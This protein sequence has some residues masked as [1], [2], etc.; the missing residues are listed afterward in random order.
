MND[1]VPM[2]SGRTAETDLVPVPVWDIWVRLFHWALVVVIAASFIT[3]QVGDLD[4]HYIAGLAVLGL[5][6]FRIL[7]GLV[8]SPTARFTHFIR[9]PRA[10]L[11]YLKYALG[12]RPSFS[13]GHN[14]AGAAMVAVLLFLLLMQAVSGLFNTDDILFE[15]P[16][17]DNA[18]SAVAGFMGSWHARFGNAILALIFIHVVVVLLYRL[19][20][21]ENLVRAMI[22]GKA[23]LPRPVAT[24]VTR[25]G[26][27]VFAS[28]LKA[29]LCAVIAAA[30][31]LA[32]H[33]LN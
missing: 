26:E 19:V 7:W 10:I 4:S 31:P 2:E 11:A 32:I 21:G 22:L 28:P 16:L 18:S 24:A 30:V 6:I 20:K 13:F 17:Y 8:G 12:R 1:K 25:N 27:A 23:R 5:V 3:D 9:G 33:S 14:P 15:G 29:I